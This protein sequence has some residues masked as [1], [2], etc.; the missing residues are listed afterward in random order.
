VL[1]RDTGLSSMLL[2]AGGLHPHS[3]DPLHLH[4]GAGPVSNLH[5]LQLISIRII[6][7]EAFMCLAQPVIFLV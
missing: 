7:F 4:A 2:L 3:V 6:D 5:M 1:F